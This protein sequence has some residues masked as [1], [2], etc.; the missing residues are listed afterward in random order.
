MLKPTTAQPQKIFK[1]LLVVFAFATLLALAATLAQ[2]KITSLQP[3]TLTLKTPN[4]NTTLAPNFQERI[5]ISKENPNWNTYSGIYYQISFPS[6]WTFQVPIQSDIDF[7]EVSSIVSPSG[8]SQILIGTKYSFPFGFGSDYVNHKKKNVSIQIGNMTYRGEETQYTGD[9]QAP[10]SSIFT[11]VKS[12]DLIVSFTDN[13]TRKE[14]DLPMLFMFGN[15]YPLQQVRVFLQENPQHAVLQYRNDEKIILQ[16]LSTFR[17]FDN[18][19]QSDTSTWITFI[20]KDNKYSIKYPSD[21]V[22]ED[23]SEEIDLYG[24]GNTQLAH[25]II[26]SKNNHKFISR[27]PLAWSP[28]VCLYPDSQPYNGPSEIYQDFVEMKNQNNVYRRPRRSTYQTQNTL[29]WTICKM[30]TNTNN[31]T[32]YSGFGVAWYETPMQYNEQILETLDQ[33]LSTFLYLD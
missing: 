21:W 1:Q 5:S 15:D 23:K 8:Y 14:T 4:T 26:I 18:E 11:I 7:P 19:D 32:T 20:T 29:S 13:K 31:F 24:D 12:E 28:S 6:N 10:Y 33:I 22:L 3:P 27:N 9:E 30:E 17:F 16:I 25:E 2:I